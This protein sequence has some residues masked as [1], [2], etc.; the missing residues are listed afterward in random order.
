[1]ALVS[2]VSTILGAGPSSGRFGSGFTLRPL[3]SSTV[4]AQYGREPRANFRS[5]N[6]PTTT[7][8]AERPV[9]DGQFATSSVF[10]SGRM[11]VV[12][13]YFESGQFIPIYA[14]VRTGLENDEFDPQ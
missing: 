4:C 8:D 10:Q 14:P 13:G 5:H 9:D 12:C 6:M 2:A 1:M 11:R 3:R 7:A